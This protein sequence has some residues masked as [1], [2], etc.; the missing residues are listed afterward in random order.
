M[1]L[2]NDNP[3]EYRAWKAMRWRC[4]PKSPTKNRY[5]DRGIKVCERWNSFDYFFEDVGPRPDKNYSL[6]R[7][8]NDRGYEP[9]NV[10][11]A[12]RIEQTNNTGRTNKVIVDGAEVT[13]MDIVRSTGLHPETVRARIKGSWTYE[14]IVSTPL[15]LSDRKRSE[16]GK[17][18]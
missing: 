15:K 12:T 13:L 1:S 3:T 4:N 9:S 5:F 6:D 18:I 16:Y 7:I 11:W 14:K 17:F 2:K 10:R 8:N